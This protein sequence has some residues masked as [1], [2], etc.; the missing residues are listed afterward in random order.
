MVLAVDEA[1]RSSMV[2]NQGYPAACGA[3]T[4]AVN[5]PTL[6]DNA[7]ARCAA[8][9][10]QQVLS[11][12][13]APSNVAVSVSQTT[14]TPPT[15]NTLTICASYTYNFI[16]LLPYGPISLKRQVTVPLI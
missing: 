16:A 15:P 5:C 1:G 8:A 6:T 2:Y 9:Q 13:L 10:A 11:S 14:G 3:Q 12:Y 4:Q 7:V